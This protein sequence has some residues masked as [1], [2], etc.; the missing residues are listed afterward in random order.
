VEAENAQAVEARRK[1]PPSST[2]IFADAFERL[3]T[4][5]FPLQELRED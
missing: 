1:L 2:C 4:L 3:S 5:Y